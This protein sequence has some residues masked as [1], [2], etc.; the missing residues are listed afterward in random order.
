L[1]IKKTPSIKYCI[2]CKAFKNS[3]KYLND[4]S[5]KE[6][7]VKDLPKMME[8]FKKRTIAFKSEVMELYASK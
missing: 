6:E 2:F 1:E 4:I 8:I 7:L 5:T 3:L